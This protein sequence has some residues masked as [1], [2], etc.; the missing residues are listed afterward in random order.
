MNKFAY[1]PPAAL[2]ITGLTTVAT[3]QTT[4]KAKSAKSMGKMSKKLFELI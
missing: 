4:P 3:A 2:L 1:L